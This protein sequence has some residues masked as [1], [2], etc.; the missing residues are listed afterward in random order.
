[1]SFS[2]PVC[3]FVREFCVQHLQEKNIRK[4][5]HAVKIESLEFQISRSV[6][7]ELLVLLTPKSKVLIL[8]QNFV[9]ILV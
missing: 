2:L 6:R 5:W 4:L 9:N 3:S 1:M 7:L 8:S